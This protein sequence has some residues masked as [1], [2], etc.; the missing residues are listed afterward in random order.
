MITSIDA[1]KASIFCNRCRKVKDKTEFL[2]VVKKKT[3]SKFGR[4]GK[5]LNLNS[6]YQKNHIVKLFFKFHLRSGITQGCLLA[7]LPFNTVLEVLDSVIKQEKDIKDIK[8]RNEEI[9]TIICRWHD[10]IHKKSK[11]IYKQCE[12]ISGFNNVGI[13]SKYKKQFNFYRSGQVSRK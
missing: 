3:L 4:K 2:L 5:F 9:K 12:L 11:R 13:R 6:N 1:E 7:T 8:M 10:C